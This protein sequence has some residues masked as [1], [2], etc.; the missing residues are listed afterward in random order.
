MNK[1]WKKVVNIQQD[2]EY[3]MFSD[4]GV[5][6]A[7]G[8]VDDLSRKTLHCNELREGF[9]VFTLVKIMTLNYP[10]PQNM[11]EHDTLD[12]MRGHYIE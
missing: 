7:T 2:N 8:T 12:T 5:P 10:V 4:D 3:L 1:N 11:S 9:A 6:I